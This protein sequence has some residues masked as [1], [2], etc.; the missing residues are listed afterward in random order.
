MKNRNFLILAILA[1]L[2]A[3][4]ALLYFTRVGMAPTTKPA[5]GTAT[6]EV[7]ALPKVITLYQKGEGESDLAAFVSK[8]LARGLRT[9]AIFRAINVLDEPQ[10]A[11][12][13]SVS[14]MPSIIFLKPNGRMYKAHA[15]YL[16]KGQI[17][18]VLKEMP[19][20]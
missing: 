6:V 14:S 13:F 15:G 12:F 20:N 11:D 9:M 8:E 2:L 19:Q 17:V 18:A 5:P 10:M 4:F 3:L 7:T 1:L 16:D